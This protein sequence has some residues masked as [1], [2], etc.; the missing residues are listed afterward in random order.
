MRPEGGEAFSIV[1]VMDVSEQ[2]IGTYVTYVST[3]GR[4]LEK[5]SWGKPGTVTSLNQYKFL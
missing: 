4:V 3:F 2:Y 5:S 1:V